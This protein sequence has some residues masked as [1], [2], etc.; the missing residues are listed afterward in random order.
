M[1]RHIQFTTKKEIVNYYISRPM[2]T[3][4]CA[5]TFSISEQSIVKILNMFKIPRWARAVLY[6]P[7]LD[8]HYFDQIDTP[9]KAYWLGLLMTD[10][11]VYQK[12]GKTQRLCLTL[13][14]SDEYLIKAFL[15]DI[16]CNKNIVR[17]KG[18]T[19]SSVQ[20]CSDTLC[21]AL[22]K[23]SIEPRKTGRQSFN[24]PRFK[25]AYLHGLIDGDGSVG[26]YSRAGCRSHYK[27]IR[28][29]GANRD[30]LEAVVKYIG[31]GRIEK[32]HEGLETITWSSMN[33]MMRVIRAVNKYPTSCLVRKKILME[34]IS[35]E[36]GKYRDNRRTTAS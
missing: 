35:E 28:L 16:K 18:R 11:C 2:T 9:Q 3:K 31:C 27:T 12:Q 30:F 20:I 6:S 33:D 19:E 24:C 5:N 17:T 8:E 10:G 1:P 22:A 26:F 25:E 23:Y 34:K 36:I 4:E 32:S 7:D 13:K 15:A 21:N 14:S 29:C